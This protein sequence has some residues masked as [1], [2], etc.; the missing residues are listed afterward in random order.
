MFY[1]AD[2]AIWLFSLFVN[3][4]VDTFKAFLDEY[5]AGKV[6]PYIKSE[7]VPETNDGPV[8]VLNNKR[9]YHVY[10]DTRAIIIITTVLVWSRGVGCGVQMKHPLVDMEHHILQWKKKKI[11][12]YIE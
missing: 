2:E 3:F 1:L 5:F 10:L 6:K 8:K 11:T 12:R 7:P 4:S 9:L